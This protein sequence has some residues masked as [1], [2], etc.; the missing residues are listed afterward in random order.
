MKDSRRLFFSIVK[1]LLLY[2]TEEKK[3]TI[4]ITK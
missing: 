1:S 4:I 2:K 3:N